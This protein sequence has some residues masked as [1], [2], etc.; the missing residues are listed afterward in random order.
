MSEHTKRDV[1]ELLAYARGADPRRPQRRR[2]ES[3]RP[4]GLRGAATT[5]S[6]SGTL[7]PR[8]NLPRLAEATRRARR[9]AARRRGAGLGTGRA[10]QRRSRLGR[11]SDE[12][13]VRLYRGARCVGVPVAVRGLRDPDRGGDGERHARGHLARRRDRGGSGRRGGARRPARPGRDRRRDR[14]GGRAA[15]RS[16]SG[17]GS[18][19]RAPSAGRRQR[20]GRPTSTARRRRVTAARRRRRRRARPAADGRRDVRRKPAPAAARAGRRRAAPRGRMTRRPDLV[21]AGVEPVHVPARFQ[22]ARMLYAVPRALRRLGAALAHFQH[23]LPLRARAR[24][25]SPSTTSPSSA[26]RP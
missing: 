17:R 22:E 20:G 25:S 15:T 12:E 18:N 21:P 9:G 2:S 23:A 10:R 14:G 26:T 7:E 19:V 13:L 4:T 16:S 8:K 3:S 5:S 24:R 1:V 11:V 6:P